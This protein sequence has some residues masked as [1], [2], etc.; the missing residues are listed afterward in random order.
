MNEQLVPNPAK[1]AGG[2]PKSSKRPTVKQRLQRYCAY[3]ALKW[4][5]QLICA[6]VV[7]FAVFWA[8]VQFLGVFNVLGISREPPGLTYF[9]PGNGPD[10]PPPPTQLLGR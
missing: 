2:A 10:P 9:V 8:I 4:T 3:F 7:L 5:L 1:P 6:V